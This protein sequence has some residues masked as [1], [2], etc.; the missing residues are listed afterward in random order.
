MFIVFMFKEIGIE[1]EI[2]QFCDRFQKTSKSL[3]DQYDERAR[4]LFCFCFG[5]M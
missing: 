1:I 3:L 5:I 2:F 4:Q